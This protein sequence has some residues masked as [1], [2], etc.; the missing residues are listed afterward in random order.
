MHVPAYCEKPPVQSASEQLVIVVADFSAV[1]PVQTG[2]VKMTSLN[3]KLVVSNLPENLSI[4]FHVHVEES[5]HVYVA[6]LHFVLV[7]FAELV[8]L[9]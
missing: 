9:I 6:R 7:M 4:V 3:T 5:I 2:F 8:T 1:R